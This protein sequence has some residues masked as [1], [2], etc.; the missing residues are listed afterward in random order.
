MDSEETRPYTVGSDFDEEEYSSVSWDTSATVLKPEDLVDAD[1]DSEEIH[2]HV[3]SSMFND[4]GVSTF[5]VN[6]LSAPSRN[7]EQVTRPQPTHEYVPSVEPGVVYP[8]VIT[9]TD[10]KKELDGTK[11]AFISYLI[12]T[13]T[14]L[15]TF[16]TP[17]VAV[18]RRFQDFVLL[19]NA[20]TRDFAACVVPPL[21]DKHRLDLGK[22]LLKNAE[23]VCKEC[24][25]DWLDIR[26][27]KR[28]NTLESFWNPENGHNNESLNRQKKGDGVLENLGDALLNAFSKIKKPDDRFIDMREN[29]D[30][31]EEN[32]E[33][34]ERLYQKIIKRQTDL[35]ADYL[36]FGSSIAGLGNLETGIKE[37]LERFGKT[38]EK[39][40][41]A[42]KQM[43]EREE[44]EYMTHIRDFLNYCHCVK[45]VLKLRDQKQV[46]FEALSD[47]LQNATIERENLLS[48]G[49]SSTGF[50]AYVREKVDNLKGVDHEQVKKERLEK[51]EAKITEL[52][53]EV[54]SSNDISNSFS[55]EVAKEYEVFQVAKNVELKEC[56]LA[57]TDSH[58]EFYQKGINLWEEI[59]PMLEKV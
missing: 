3:S 43:T 34:V 18:R 32:L 4:L 31:L 27:Y 30:K 2:E 50:S 22:N 46:D 1:I 37:Q 5:S 51:L 24:W 29:V 35:E 41:E 23:Q 33:T 45:Y 14:T 8:M 57:Y 26:I 17:T 38:I 11:D 53:E 9:V 44:Q 58:V 48:T 21:P 6:T 52:K 49:K 40:S 25:K 55:N 12:T 47:Y 20:L 10:A 15:E 54:E 56:L 59:I 13:K 28:A 16:S 19:H 7:K 42:W 36:E 39:F